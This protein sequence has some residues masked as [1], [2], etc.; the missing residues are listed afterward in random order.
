M[1]FYKEICEVQT[2]KFFFYLFL[3]VSNLIC[4]SYAGKRQMYPPFLFSKSN[5]KNAEFIDLELTEL[6]LNERFPFTFSVI[7]VKI[8]LIYEL[9]N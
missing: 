1:L 9:I 6:S 3:L 4:S 7:S 2:T 8:P 5:A